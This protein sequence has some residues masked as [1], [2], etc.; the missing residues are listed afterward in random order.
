[1]RKV[2]GIAIVAIGAVTLSF[3]PRA[4][5]CELPRYVEP[6]IVVPYTFSITLWGSQGPGQPALARN[7]MN[8]GPI[9]G[10]DSNGQVTTAASLAECNV[11]RAAVMAKI[12]NNARVATECYPTAPVVVEGQIH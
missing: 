12:D 10:T 11:V 6:G 1:M 7:L 3:V 5:A 4:K 8:Q 9:V 2:R